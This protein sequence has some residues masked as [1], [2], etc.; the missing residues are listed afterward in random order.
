MYAIAAIKA[1]TLE[2]N[3]NKEK[4]VWHASKKQNQHNLLIQI[5]VLV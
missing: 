2:V 4:A 5:P 1:V 3:R